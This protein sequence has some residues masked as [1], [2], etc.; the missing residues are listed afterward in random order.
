MGYHLLHEKDEQEHK[1]EQGLETSWIY[2]VYNKFERPF[3]ENSTKRRVMLGIT[4]LLLAGSVLMF[5][6]KSVLVKML[7]FDNKNEFQVVVD[8]PE[9]TTL[10]KTAVVTQEIAQYLTIIPEVVDYQN[11]IGTSAPIT[12]QWFGSSLR[13]AWWKQYGGYSSEFIAQRRP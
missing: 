1:A 8:M 13:F 11:Y 12:F 4:V 3:L 9:G 6:T 10:E 2:R 7:P 5:F